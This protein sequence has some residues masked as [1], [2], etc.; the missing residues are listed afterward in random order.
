MFEPPGPLFAAPLLPLSGA[1]GIFVETHSASGGP[2]ATAERRKSA[3][4][5]VCAWLQTLLGLQADSVQNQVEHVEALWESFLRRFED[6]DVALDRLC[7][8]LLQTQRKWQKKVWQEVMRRF[9]ISVEQ[10]ERDPLRDIC[11]YF[12]LWGELGNLRF[13]PELVC[14]LFTAASELAVEVASR[15][16]IPPRREGA[17]LEEVVKPIFAVMLDETFDASSGA[18]KF[19]FGKEP[20][21]ARACNYDDWNELFWDPRRLKR[22]LL[23]QGAGTARDRRLLSVC[24]SCADVWERL[25]QVDWNLTLRNHKSHLELH[26]PVPL[27]VGFYRIFLLHTLALAALI[28]FW[29]EWLG[30]EQDR[31]G[32]LWAYWGWL[33]RAALGLIAPAWMLLFQI[34]FQYLT[35]CLARRNRL[36]G[37]LQ[38]CVDLTPVATY[39]LLILQHNSEGGVKE[40]LDLIFWKVRKFDALLVLHVFCSV[41]VLLLALGPRSGNLYRWRFYPTMSRHPVLPAGIFWVVTIGAWLIFSS[42]VTMYCSQVLIVI[43]DIYDALGLNLPVLLLVQNLLI[44]VPTTLVFFSTL[45]FFMNFVMSI[46]G[47]IV[48][49]HRLG[50]CRLWCYRR[51]LFMQYLPENTVKKIMHLP[52]HEERQ[53]GFLERFRWWRRMSALELQAFVSVWNELLEELRS[54]DLLTDE[55][56][57]SLAFESAAAAEEGNIPRLFQATP[58]NSLPTNKEAQR[59]IVTLARSVLVEP[60]PPA[61][62][63]QMPTLSVLIPHYSETIRYSKKDL[64]DSQG[65]SDLLRFLI[66]YYRDEFRN[67]IERMEHARE[68]GEELFGSA[69]VEGI[70]KLELPLCEWASQRMQTLWRTVHGI[71]RA[72]ARALSLLAKHQE[73]ESSPGTRT[74]GRLQV[75]IAMQQYAKF[76]DEHSSTFSPEHLAA[77]EAMFDIFGDLLSIAYIEEQEGLQGKLYY[78]CLIDASCEKVHLGPGCVARRPK[79]RIELPGF[80]ILGHGKSDN[81][82]CAVIFTRGE[83]L[84][85]IDANQEAYFEASLMLPSALQEFCEGERHGNRRPGIVGFREHIFSAV[86]LLG[87]LAADSEFTFGTM[88]QRTLDWPLNARLHYGHPDLMD[89]LQVVQQGGVSKGTRGLNLSE[90]VFAGLDLTLRGGWTV[91]REYFHVGKGRDMGFM[92]TL[93]FYAKVSMGNAEQAITRQWMRMG[94]H[95]QLSSL[96]G[97]FYSH[98][99]FYANQSMVNRATKALCF[100]AA[101]YTMSGSV[102]ELFSEIAVDM[103]SSYFGYFYILFVLAT[104]MP[105]VFEV[106]L[107][108]GFRSSFWSLVSSLISL[109]PVF[110]SFQSK[111]MA[112]FFDTTLKYGGAQYI[113]T[114]RGLATAREPVVKLF[115]CFAASHMH[116]AM[117]ALVFIGFSIG[118]DYGIGFYACTIF[119]VASW[120]VA[121]FLFNPRQFESKRQ[122]LLEV[123][124]WMDWMRC[125]SPGFSE[126]TS[127]AAWQMRL[128]EVRRS[129][130]L[131]QV[132]FGNCRFF[133]ML[134]SFALVFAAYPNLETTGDKYDMLVFSP[135]LGHFLISLILSFLCCNRASVDM[136]YQLPAFIAAASTV[137]E[138][139]CLQRSQLHLALFHRYLCLRWMLEAADGIAAHRPG[140]RMLSTLH[141]A[142]RLWAFSFRFLRDAALGF[143]LAIFGVTLAGLPGIHALHTLF[144]FRTR[145]PRDEGLSESPVEEDSDSPVGEAVTSQ[146]DPLANFIRNFAPQSSLA[147]PRRGLRTSQ[148]AR[149]LG[150]M[151]GPLAD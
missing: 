113:P 120:L 84:Q 135:P 91:Y 22:S 149:S 76:A 123:R 117:E 16:S 131:F 110:S 47:H 45:C 119:S 148:S 6:P 107:E 142:C 112:Y 43:W 111:L 122:Q 102:T 63:K 10:Q 83:I 73:P 75:V 1:A 143:M 34:S 114:G 42:R 14:F 4:R 55:E 141:D 60:L 33:C 57:T 74:E 58:M 138:L 49:M 100:T 15:A 52:P 64:F 51:G 50:G 40:L 53:T 11:L 56:A 19:R 21:P 70:E 132:L 65:S 62:V 66:K 115:R 87:R 44:I 94:L 8:Q 144:L 130:P 23:L 46:V 9:P 98:V 139:I 29:I 3:V 124:E 93:S 86:G 79:F 80:P 145:L 39:V 78:S 127:W 125:P 59:R 151:G 92:S 13:C 30:E 81:Q 89:K 27:L 67:F 71:C 24:S 97:V 137:G 88:I 118:V 85:M 101:F 18:P 150:S 69:G 36:K 104:M 28:W 31:G 90:D 17:F 128:Q 129:R 37:L 105:Y 147:P 108:E 61:T 2:Y 41:L 38:L 20:A 82:N 95:L 134:C 121:P 68:S 5:H 96:L 116:D 146:D 136:S 12:L 106:L 48:G 99:G 103:V 77:V 140:G 35:P 126:E 7:K 72:Y 54:G 133:A 26:S 32:R 109:S 25:P